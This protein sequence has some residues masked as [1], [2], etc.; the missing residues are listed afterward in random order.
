MV[1]MVFPLTSRSIESTGTCARA[2]N[3]NEQSYSL[4][5]CLALHPRGAGSR[6]VRSL[7]IADASRCHSRRL[8]RLARGPVVSL[9]VLP[10]GLCNDKLQLFTL[11]SDPWRHDRARIVS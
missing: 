9:H 5:S 6:L 10:L 7:G 4:R 1:G 11:K 3:R 2:Q 8:R